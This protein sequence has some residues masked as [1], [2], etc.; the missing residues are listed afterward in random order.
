MIAVNSTKRC[1]Y[2]RNTERGQV[3]SVLAAKESTKKKEKGAERKEVREGKKKK[4]SFES[5]MRGDRHVC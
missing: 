3:A 2:S 5:E 1:T 4:L